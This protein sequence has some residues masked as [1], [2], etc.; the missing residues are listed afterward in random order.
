MYLITAY[1]LQDPA[2]AGPIGGCSQCLSPLIYQASSV[3]FSVSSQLCPV[4][5]SIQL[6]SISGFNHIYSP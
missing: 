5:G 4:G 2:I 6:R 3:L 1:L